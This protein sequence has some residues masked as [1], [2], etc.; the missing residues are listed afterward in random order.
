DD[1]LFISKTSSG[2]VLYFTSFVNG[3]WSSEELLWDAQDP[4]I[5]FDHANNQQPLIC[6]RAQTQ[7][8]CKLY[9]NN[10]WQTVFDQQI[11]ES[12]SD[13]YPYGIVLRANSQGIMYLAYNDLVN[14][15]L[16]V[17]TSIDAARDDWQFS[18]I[19]SWISDGYDMALAADGSP[20]IA[21][22]LYDTAI[23]G[24]PRNRGTGWDSEEISTAKDATS[25]SLNISPSNSLQAV[26]SNDGKLMLSEKGAT[27]WL[28]YNVQLN[29]EIEL[30]SLNVTSDQTGSVKIS[31]FD[32]TFDRRMLLSRKL[33]TDFS[34]P[35][36]WLV[37]RPFS[38]DQAHQSTMHLT[39]D[40]QLYF[41]YSHNKQL[42]RNN[43][44]T[45]LSYVP[46][47]FKGLYNINNTLSS[48]KDSDWDGIKDDKDEEN[49]L[50]IDND[51]I[52]NIIDDDIDGDLRLNEDDR[53]PFDKNEW[54]DLDFDGLGDNSDPD[55][56]ND[57]ILNED[58]TFVADTDNDGI[59][60]LFDD[61]D[62]ND[63]VNDDQDQRPLDANLIYNP[64]NDTGVDLCTDGSDINLD[65]ATLIEFT[66]Q[67]GALGLDALAA[68]GEMYK[69][70]SGRKGF[71]FTKIAADGSVYTLAFPTEFQFETVEDEEKVIIPEFHHC[72]LDNITGLMW[73][74]KHANVDE[75]E[76][77]EIG[78]YRSFLQFDDTHFYVD[79]INAA[80][81]C[82]YDNWRLPTPKELWGIT[83]YSLT[84][85][86]VED[87]EYMS[88]MGPDLNVI[89][90][91]DPQFFPLAM[92]VY[93]TSERL[94][95]LERD[96]EGA[97]ILDDNGDGIV[98]DED[99]WLVWA[100]FVNNSATI[101][102]NKVIVDQLYQK[103]IVGIRL[104]RD[105]TVGE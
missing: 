72:V 103:P 81:R 105:T 62:D 27:R 98:L 97:P 86:M 41:Y 43:I 93:W 80:Q 55:M 77:R 16:I 92:G 99:D 95:T 69:K 83:D 44:A 39:S 87:L 75:D 49:I 50:D 63:G 74:T 59:D 85:A 38:I 45:Y 20:R 48:K 96:G 79:A 32:P 24:I 57:G 56:D 53:F 102:I 89:R 51:L 23:Y 10:Q 25:I 9:K 17:V 36:K 28:N 58:D 71:D 101:T 88:D 5:I 54:A 84:Q 68:K 14:N 60:N 19:S 104:V 100:Y 4:Q 3:S 8:I 61:D 91:M 64:F 40:D 90:R 1:Q 29:A 2:S 11:L 15:D 70:G 78:H 37:L 47:D 82:G 6:Y 12:S 67:D 30:N 33:K 66:Q 76:Y 26:F 21:F 65:C 7:L 35:E 42:K 94:I 52:L 31:Y 13:E 18:K 46:N 73:E 22:L 34:Q